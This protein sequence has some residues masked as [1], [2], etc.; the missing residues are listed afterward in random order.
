MKI[1]LGELLAKYST[2]KAIDA[3]RVFVYEKPRKIGYISVDNMPH[4][5]PMNPDEEI[6]IIEDA[7]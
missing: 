3:A 1:K 6:E 2:E 7:S 4:K 5:Y